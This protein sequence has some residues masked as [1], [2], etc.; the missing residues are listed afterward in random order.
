M[1]ELICNYVCTYMYMRVLCAK[2]LVKTKIK[3]CNERKEGNARLLSGSLEVTFNF[4]KSL[5]S[6]S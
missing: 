3:T 6:V 1:C 4:K 2:L 5:D